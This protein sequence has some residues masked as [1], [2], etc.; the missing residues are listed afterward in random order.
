M[1]GLVRELERSV[2]NCGDGPGFLGSV[3]I[4]ASSSSSIKDSSTG[5]SDR[6]V[7]S[8]NTSPSMEDEALRADFVLV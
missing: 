7:V 6:M 2:S 1:D 5:M 3:L 8:K 4:M